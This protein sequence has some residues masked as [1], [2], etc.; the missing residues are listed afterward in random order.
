M[1]VKF[2]A[3]NR[4]IKI[5]I[6]RI[7]NDFYDLNDMSFNSTMENSDSSIDQMFT[8]PCKL[9]KLLYNETLECTDLNLGS[10]KTILAWFTSILFVLVFPT[11]SF[12]IKMRS[13]RV[14]KRYLIMYPE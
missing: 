12:V 2:F 3:L 11:V 6:F 9:Q 10:G 4:T 5:Q 13:G 1:N 14:S 7:T 8:L